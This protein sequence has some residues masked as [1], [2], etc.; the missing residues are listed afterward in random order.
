ML[1]GVTPH[2]ARTYLRRWAGR[3]LITSI[4]SP[5]NDGLPGTKLQVI[6]RSRCR[7]PR[8]RIVRLGRDAIMLRRSGGAGL[9]LSKAATESNEVRTDGMRT[10]GRHGTQEVKGEWQAQLGIDTHTAMIEA[11]MR[12]TWDATALTLTQSDFTSLAIASN[13]MTLASG[14]PRSA[15][16]A[17]V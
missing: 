15:R 11:I 12:D 3:S 8:D 17:H 6:P 4:R 9:N 5:T 7:A 10:R 1:I 16:A 2:A 13:V 14:D